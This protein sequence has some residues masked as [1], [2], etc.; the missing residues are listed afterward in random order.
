MFFFLF[1]LHK[2]FFQSEKYSKKWDYINVDEI[3]SS[4][5]LLENYK[6]CLM[7]Q[8]VCTIEGQ[9]LKSKCLVL[10]FFLI[11]LN[12]LSKEINIDL[13]FIFRKHSKRI[14]K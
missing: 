8:G 1:L 5:R 3:L 2:L 11:K 9:E 13:Y 14:K 12:R 10:F 4:Q 6:K 7:D